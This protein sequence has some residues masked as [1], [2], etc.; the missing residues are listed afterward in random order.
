MTRDNTPWAAKLHSFLA[1]KDLDIKHLLA[2]FD[3]ISKQFPAFCNDIILRIESEE[4]LISIDQNHFH[5][6]PSDK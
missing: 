6:L 3:L 4:G 5:D 1:S 2:G